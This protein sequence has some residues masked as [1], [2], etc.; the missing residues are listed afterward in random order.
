MEDA[1][2]ELVEALD[3]KPSNILLKTLVS[4]AQTA[5]DAASALAWLDRADPAAF[6]PASRLLA[7]QYL[8]DNERFETALA[9]CAGTSGQLLLAS[10]HCLHG[11]GRNVEALDAYNEALS[12]DAALADEALRR[13]I[14]PVAQG[15]SGAGDR[16][17][18]I[19]L[20]G[21][22]LDAGTAA[23]EM[24]A[25]PKTRER[26]TFDDV[27][28][29][30]EVKRQIRRRIITPMQKPS[31]FEK[32]KRKAGGGVL[33]YGPPGC[34]KTLMARATAGEAGAEFYQIQISDIL[35]MYIGESEKRMTSV[36][37]MARSHT[38]AV[39]FFDEI[40]ALAARRRYGE[41]DNRASLVSTFLTEMDGFAS[42][43]SGLLV[44]AASNVPW[45]I[46]SAF[47][48]PG[49]FDRSVFVPPPD[50][51]A[52][53]T[54]LELLLT[55]RPIETGLDLAPIV[56]RTS[57]FSGADLSGLVEEACDIAIENSLE[58]NSI[59]N[60]TAWHFKD[61]LSD[62]RPSTIDWLSQARN[63]VKFSNEGGFYDDVARFLD[64]HA[65]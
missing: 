57:G 30:D 13:R 49:R 51:E 25:A 7:S 29:L 63:Y 21:K 20:H 61:A 44:L 45:S 42:N 6:A 17:V 37:E 46:D 9:W 15:V 23:P 56:Q 2:S 50:Q 60:L 12:L 1:L 19:D 41:N 58:A 40:E 14:S 33:L 18:V 26:I 10:A 39:I 4:E 47:L 64:K 54:I 52:R 38:P 34:G 5:V 32:F 65:K 59:E 27:G 28:G 53:R 3:A 35:D 43:N 24:P 22:R 48:R 55:N 16:G 11:L 8:R 62:L 31:L 36:F